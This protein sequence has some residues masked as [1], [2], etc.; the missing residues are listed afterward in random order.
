M[1][2]QSQSALLSQKVARIGTNV[3]SDFLNIPVRPHS[4]PPPA[5]YHGAEIAISGKWQGNVTVSTSENLGQRIASRMFR[6]ESD[7]VEGVDIVD[8]L[9]ELT[10]II[11]GNIKAI[12]PGPSQLSL[13][14]PLAVLPGEHRTTVD[15]LIYDDEEGMLRISLQ[16]AES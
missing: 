14:V 3:L 11:A 5:I 7:S 2:T 15:V 10:N 13:P 12:L 4:G 9:T 8:A 16:P 6:K 1:D